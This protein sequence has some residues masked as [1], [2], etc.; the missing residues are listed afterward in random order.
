[1]LSKSLGPDHRPFL[2]QTVTKFGGPE[3]LVL[4]TR[5]LS[6]NYSML[7]RILLKQEKCSVVAK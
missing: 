3:R 7:G 4:K 2:D 1:M 6:Q 5:Q